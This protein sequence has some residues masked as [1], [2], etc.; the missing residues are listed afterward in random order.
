MCAI[1]TANLICYWHPIF[2]GFI[3]QSLAFFFVAL[4]LFLDLIVLLGQGGQLVRPMRR[5]M[6]L[7]NHHCSSL[8]SF[9]SPPGKLRLRAKPWNARSS[10]SLSVTWYPSHCLLIV[11]ILLHY[12]CTT[13]A[14]LIVQRSVR[15]WLRF[16][17]MQLFVQ[18][19]IGYASGRGSCKMIPMGDIY[20]V[21]FCYSSHSFRWT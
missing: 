6:P 3:L 10:T 15:L 7:H 16:V 13:T 5:W 18:F 17:R 12:C 2:Y 8:Y 1:T 19:W 20:F 14:Y 9:S 4:C 21:S 11:W